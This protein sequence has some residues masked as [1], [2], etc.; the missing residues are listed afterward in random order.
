M[1]SMRRCPR[2]LR[3][4]ESE[5]I[6][7]VSAI[8]IT[9]A[10]AEANSAEGVVRVGNLS[11]EGDYAIDGYLDSAFGKRQLN[12]V[13]VALTGPIGGAATQKCADIILDEAIIISAWWIA[14]IE[15]LDIVI[16]LEAVALYT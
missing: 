9:G 10:G 14:W 4:P 8:C 11:S 7:L 6:Y 2:S 3:D 15:F 13:P 12:Q 1:A 5:V 16:K